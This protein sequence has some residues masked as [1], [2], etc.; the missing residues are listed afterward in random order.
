MESDMSPSDKESTLDRSRAENTINLQESYLSSRL[1]F[2]PGDKVD[3]GVHNVSVSM[4]LEPQKWTVY[5]ARAWA[6]VQCIHYKNSVKK[7]RRTNVLLDNVCVY[8]PGGSLTVIIGSSGAGK[9]TL[10][11]VVGGGLPLRGRKIQGSVTFNGQPMTDRIS[12]AYVRQEDFLIPSLTVRETLQYSAD[13]RL[14]PPTTAQ[15]RR[16]IVEQVI[17]ELGL[18]GCANTMI[19][20]GCSGGEKRRTSIGI[21]MLANSSILLCDEPTTGNHILVA[22]NFSCRLG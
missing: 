3:V 7:K 19:G 18:R 8:M 17:D 9:T 1:P 13:L 12:R 21:Q 14:P 5:A 10:L 2:G 4:D 22:N 20:K 11:D 6:A 16:E 15:E